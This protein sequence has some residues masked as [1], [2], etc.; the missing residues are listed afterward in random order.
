M[1]LNNNLNSNKYNY[2]VDFYYSNYG[3]DGGGECLVQYWNGSSWDTVQTI[4][5][6]DF[7]PGPWIAATSIDL[8][9]YD[10]EDGKIRW[11]FTTGGTTTFANDF[12]LDDISITTEFASISSSSVSSSST[13]SSSSSLSSSSLSSSSSSLSSS[14]SSLSSS[15]SS[16]SVTPIPIE[17]LVNNYSLYQT[18]SAYLSTN[19]WP[20][21]SRCTWSGLE[22]RSES[23]CSGNKAA[24]P[25]TGD[26]NIDFIW[27]MTAHTNI[28]NSDTLM[29]CCV[30]DSPGTFTEQVTYADGIMIV[31]RSGPS[32]ELM[33]K[34][35]C[36]NNTNENEVALSGTPLPTGTMYSRLTRVG[37]TATAYAYSDL[38]RTVLVGST[39]IT[40]PTTSF[41]YF[42]AVASIESASGAY[43]S[44]GYAQNFQI[45]P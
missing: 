8:S 10:N 9:S 29:L 22:R 30:C 4:G 36:A 34:L 21:I 40:V 32:Q 24:S 25:F 14:S 45:T 7:Y 19:N 12:G 28:A 42:T 1:E 43:N 27:T 33:M 37:T 5:W 41:D 13:S 2:T 16:F 3:V 44:N 17:D 11:H 38:E 31:L 23:I 20:E 35:Y 18:G 15:S 6:N 26:F 39:S